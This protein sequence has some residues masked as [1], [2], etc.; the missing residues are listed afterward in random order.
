M[1]QQLFDPGTAQYNQ[2]VR[3]L[4]TK[5]LTL[6]MA[7]NQKY[8]NKELAFTQARDATGMAKTFADSN[9]RSAALQNTYKAFQGFEEFA[10]V[11]AGQR[12]PSGE[13]SRTAEM[14]RTAAYQALLAK[15][16]DIEHSLRQTWGAA[17]HANLHQNAVRQQN[18][19]MRNRTQLGMAPTAKRL[20]G[21]KGTNW[22]VAAFNIAKT[23][24]SIASGLQSMGAFGVLDPEKGGGNAGLMNWL[25]RKG[26]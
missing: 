13:G 17:Y 22:G 6:A 5:R 26:Y 11:R 7:A 15:R 8:R 23:G 2:Q 12:G 3:A 1:I 24:I 16:Q 18:E 25:S 10:R 21:T 4:N 14:G 9:V 20:E 19:E